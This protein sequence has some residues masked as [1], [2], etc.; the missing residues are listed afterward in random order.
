MA[1][2]TTNL[3]QRIALGVEAGAGDGIVGIATSLRLYTSSSTPSKDGT[4]FVE[5]PDGNG[6][7]TGGIAISE[8]DWVSSL[9]GGNEQVVLKPGGV[10]PQFQAS[11]GT[12]AN[13][14]GAY[15]ADGSGNVLA[16]FP[17]PGGAVSIGAGET[18][19]VRDTTIKAI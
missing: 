10:D 19:T 11:G 8:S 14:A 3:G 5:V 16:W 6:Y 1:N 13:V 2:N 18:I 15:I 4:G 17:R 12:I 7:S 9:D